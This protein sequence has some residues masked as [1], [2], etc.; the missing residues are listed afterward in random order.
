MIELDANFKA[1]AQ[2]SDMIKAFVEARAKM[3]NGFV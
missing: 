3:Q 2:R 1:G